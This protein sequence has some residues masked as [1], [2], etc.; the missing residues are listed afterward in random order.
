MFQTPK[1]WTHYT[2]VQRRERPFVGGEPTY[3]EI[4]FSGADAYNAMMRFF[5]DNGIADVVDVIET[6]YG[7]DFAPTGPPKRIDFE[8]GF[9]DYRTQAREEFKDELRRKLAEP[10]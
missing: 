3:S 2:V 6:E 4:S 5:Y 8:E 7:E 9:N 10:D 1:F